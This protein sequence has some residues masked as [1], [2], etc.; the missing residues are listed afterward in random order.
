MTIRLVNYDWYNIIGTIP[1]VLILEAMGFY[2]GQGIRS[3]GKY[4][5]YFGIL[6]FALGIAA[7]IAYIIY[8][9]YS[10]K[11]TPDYLE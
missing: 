2:F 8:Y 7:V 1:K 3:A 9:K 4:V 10:K 11:Q 5:D 6:S